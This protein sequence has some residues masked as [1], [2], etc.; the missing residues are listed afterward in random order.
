MPKCV[1]MENIQGILH[2]FPLWIKENGKQF[3]RKVT[4]IRVILSGLFCTFCL[5]ALTKPVHFSL[6]SC[7]LALLSN[8]SQHEGGWVFSSWNNYAEF[9]PA[10]SS[11]PT[12]NVQQ[13]VLHPHVITHPEHQARAVIEVRSFTMQKAAVN[14]IVG[15]C[16]WPG[17]C[18]T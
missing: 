17:T 15:M 18:T 4:R 7:K 1:S 6:S 12:H 2:V 9:S 14:H 3:R 16:C 8:P 5:K 11:P 10:P 13:S